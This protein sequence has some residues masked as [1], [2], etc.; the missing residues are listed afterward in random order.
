MSI[1]FWKLSKKANHETDTSATDL[2]AMINRLKFKFKDVHNTSDLAI[3]VKEAENKNFDI[4]DLIEINAMLSLEIRNL[5]ENGIKSVQVRY[6]AN[7]MRFFILPLSVV[8][9]IFQRIGNLK[10]M[11]QP[12]SLD[13]KHPRDKYV[14]SK[15]AAPYGFGVLKSIPF[16]KALQFLKVVVKSRA[17]LLLVAIPY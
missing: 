15:F 4:Q 1:Q 2:R 7:L 6:N 5:K 14:L 3:F 9:C 8:K 12:L 16:W 11:T 17:T 13:P 10:T